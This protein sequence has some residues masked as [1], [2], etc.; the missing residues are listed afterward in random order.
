VKSA[1]KSV[2]NKH[3]KFIVLDRVELSLVVRV[4]WIDRLYVIICLFDQFDL[5]LNFFA[6]AL[7]L[8]LAPFVWKKPAPD[9]AR[10]TIN[11]K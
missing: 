5:A 3:F 1:T 4:L 6:L 11:S 9:D 7:A 8:S 10:T 2:F